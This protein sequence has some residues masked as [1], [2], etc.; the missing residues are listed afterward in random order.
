VST[1]IGVA[2]CGRWGEHVV[3][4]LVGLGAA[5]FVA[6]PDPARRD[7]ARSLGARATVADVSDLLEVA[8]CGGFV[9]VT[10]ASEH[11]RICAAVLELGVPVFVEKPPGTSLADV[12]ELA[13]LGA[14][15]LF[16]MHKWRY[17]PGVLEIADLARDGVLG[18]LHGLRTTRTGP[19]RLP[20][21]VD[22]TWHLA[23]H[24]VAIALEILGSVPQVVAAVGERAGDGRLR[25]V[26]A[27]LRAG[28][29]TEHRLVVAAD[30]REYTREIQV[31][32]SEATAVLVRPDAPT[33][34]IVRADGSTEHRPLADDLPL[35]RELAA[36]VAYCQ[37]GPAP[38]S[39]MVEALAIARCLAAIQER[40]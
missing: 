30:A 19:Q 2:G 16:V 27:T 15:R 31:V 9:V 26:E 21:D 18:A 17:H 33:V 39:S 24:D 8:E 3:R 29:E 40:A 32:G 36:F 10:P 5:V 35:R 4:D 22:V 1:T 20:D 23:V 7:V 34:D 38:K 12:E 11:R 25:R 14:D 6:D 37:G 13:A 28:P